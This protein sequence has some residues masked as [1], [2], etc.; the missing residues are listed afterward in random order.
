MGKLWIVYRCRGASDGRF[1]KGFGLSVHL[2]AS[3]FDLGTRHDLHL[4]S[5]NVLN[6]PWIYFTCHL[7]KREGQ[8]QGQMSNKRR[9]K[10][11]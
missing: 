6:N 9:E 8:G 11:K 7:K 3:V 1:R 10:K 5:N 2:L 4:A